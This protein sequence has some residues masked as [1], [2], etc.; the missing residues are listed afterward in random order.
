MKIQINFSG[1]ESVSTDSE[2]MLVGGFSGSFSF[3]TIATNASSVG[4]NN[5]LGGNCSDFCGTVSNQC[6]VKCNNYAGCG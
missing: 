2:Q 3:G 1:F 4:S 5:C 6:N